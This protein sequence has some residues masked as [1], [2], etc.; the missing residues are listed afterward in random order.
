MY[1]LI[2]V[3][4]KTPVSMVWQKASMAFIC[5]EGLLSSTTVAH[6]YFMG[7]SG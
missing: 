4:L 2:Y 1:F 3:L 7:H 6:E 5:P